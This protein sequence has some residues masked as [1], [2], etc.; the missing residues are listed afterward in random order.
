MSHEW[1]LVCGLVLEVLAFALLLA[2]VPVEVGVSGCVARLRGAWRWL[3]STPTREHELSFHRLRVA[4]LR[5]LLIT[6]LV[7]TLWH[8]AQIQTQWL[9]GA[10]LEESTMAKE[11]SNS[12]HTFLL[13]AL[14]FAILAFPAA[15][16][17]MDLWYAVIQLILFL[18]IFSS[19]DSYMALG[20][21]GDF[22]LPQR[23]LVIRTLIAVCCTNFFLAVAGSLLYVLVVM[24]QAS[25]HLAPPEVQT[26]LAREAQ[27]CLLVLIGSLVIRHPLWEHAR[28]DQSLKKSV[29]ELSAVCR[30]LT[31]L[32]DA[33][34]FLDDT[35]QFESGFAAFSTLLLHGH[36]I[37]A[38]S[39]VKDFVSYFGQDADHVRTQLTATV[40]GDS[41]PVL[42]FNAKLKDSLGNC[43]NVELLHLQFE[44]ED[45][46]RCHLV[47]LREYQDI[48]AVAPLTDM[49][50]LPGSFVGVREYQDVFA[51]APL[52]DSPLEMA[53]QGDV[54]SGEEL[55]FDAYSLDILHVSGRL[56][57]QVAEL[58]FPDI[59]NSNLVDLGQ[60]GSPSLVMQVQSHVN[61]SRNGLCP[62]AHFDN[63]WLWSTL[64]VESLRLERDA[65]VGTLV[66]TLRIVTGASVQITEGVATASQGPQ[67]HSVAGLWAG[68]S[69]SRSSRGSSKAASSKCSERRRSGRG[70]D[71]SGDIRA[72][73]ECHVKL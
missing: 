49:E 8:L 6:H 24:Q 67:G 40:G 43:L 52:A 42:A 10:I 19:R 30:L 62:A 31:G 68:R 29:V 56:C 51:V 41:S 3:W 47:G 38:E 20:E 73:R 36:G 39:A 15:T 70:S 7:V 48:S 46:R 55:L 34:V 37:P 9:S 32:C 35:L 33:L 18:P 17:F 50:H 5:K 25:Q 16:R 14:D 26:I 71:T 59:Q 28:L 23:L 72:L 22:W 44:R 63:V 2:K 66:G 27:A 21:I 64:K 4:F 69:R 12:P 57:Q 61:K 53:K 1:L 13:A 54:D 11:L 58:G 60:R 45:G 65:L